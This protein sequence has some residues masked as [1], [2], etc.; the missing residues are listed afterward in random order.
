MRLL[1]NSRIAFWEYII[2]A[3]LYRDNA[4]SGDKPLWLWWCILGG[5]QGMNATRDLGILVETCVY[6]CVYVTVRM[7]CWGDDKIRM[8]S[9]VIVGWYDIIVRVFYLGK[10]MRQ[11]MLLECIS[12]HNVNALYIGLTCYS[13]D[14]VLLNEDH[15]CRGRQHIIATK[16]AL[17]ISY[18]VC[19]YI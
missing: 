4:L 8:R 1:G 11:C 17:S 18:D 15:M 19:L 16:N 2:A 5:W 13:H 6:M 3:S 14:T 12:Y 9:C 10:Y 7:H